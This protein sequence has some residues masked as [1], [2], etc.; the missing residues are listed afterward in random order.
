MRS[1]I[2]FGQKLRRKVAQTL[3]SVRAVGGTAKIHV[4]VHKSMAAFLA[5]A[6]CVVLEKFYFISALGA[7]DFKDSPRL[8]VTAVLSRAFHGVL[9]IS[10]S[11]GG[12]SIAPSI[13]L[14]LRSFT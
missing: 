9:S 14:P 3:L 10:H 6:R 4:R 7:L 12:A 2:S 8:P 5:Q 1:V 13:T 11:Q